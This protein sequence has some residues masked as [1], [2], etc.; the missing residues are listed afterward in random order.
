MSRWQII[1]K[2]NYFSDFVGTMT[3]SQLTKWYGDQTIF[4]TGATGFMGKIMVEKL[5]RSCPS[6]KLCLLIRAKKGKTPQQR[7]NDFLEC[8][9]SIKYL[10]SVIFMLKLFAY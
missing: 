4:I 5:L 10:E 1:N 2:A 3:E 8:A 7:V 9:V 6:S